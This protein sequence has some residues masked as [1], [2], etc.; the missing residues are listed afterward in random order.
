MNAE[1][2]RKRRRTA[3]RILTTSNI[4]QR[5]TAC[6]RDILSDLTEIPAGEWEHFESRLHALYVRKNE[7]IVRE[8]KPIDRMFLIVRGAF[9]LFSTSAGREINLGFDFDGRFVTSYDSFL[10]SEPSTISIQA[11]EDSE[12]IY[13]DRATLLELYRRHICWE[14]IGRLM[15]ERQY[16][17]KSRKE[18]EIRTRSPEERYRRM[19][20]DKPYLIERVPQYHLASFLGVTPETLSRI[21]SRL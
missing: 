12:L 9:R 18:N 21:R 16:A 10:T 1:S 13:F 20:E 19:L 14:R 7:C 8:G 4:R 6:L 2:E 15:A 17:K 5:G 11:L 3:K